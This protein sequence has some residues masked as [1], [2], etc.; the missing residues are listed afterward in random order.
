MESKKS[1]TCYCSCSLN[2]DFHQNDVYRR[3][4]VFGTLCC[5]HSEPF[6]SPS[7][8][9]NCHVNTLDTFAKPT[10]MPKLAA[11]L[12]TLR[13]LPV[14]ANL[15]RVLKYLAYPVYITIHT[16]QHIISTPPPKKKTSGWKE[17][18]FNKYSLF[19]MRVLSLAFLSLVVQR[20]I[21]V[22]W[23]SE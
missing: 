21:C 22:D 16:H 14:M 17:F 11:Y 3:V 13:P 20:P 19:S 8:T 7:Q 18:S 2:H 15:A 23:R 12:L 6:H 1:H 10:R 5:E 9:G 4:A